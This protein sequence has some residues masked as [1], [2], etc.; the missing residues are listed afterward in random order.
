MLAPRL[1]PF[2][3]ITPPPSPL[4]P[5]PVHLCTLR[6]LSGIVSLSWQGAPSMGVRLSA[7]QPRRIY[8]SMI[9]Y[10]DRVMEIILRVC[11]LQ[12][13]WCIYIQH[14]Y[15]K[16]EDQILFTQKLLD[17]ILGAMTDL[18]TTLHCLQEVCTEAHALHMQRGE[19]GTL[20]IVASFSVCEIFWE[21]LPILYYPIEDDQCQSKFARPQGYV[22]TCN[23]LQQLP[24]QCNGI[25]LQHQLHVTDACNRVPTPITN[26]VA[27]RSDSIGCWFRPLAQCFVVIGL[28]QLDL[29][30]AENTD[31]SPHAHMN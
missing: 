14:K 16:I 20:M 27:W 17:R 4:V 3:L 10:I 24:I 8:E 19:M 18:R 13:A 2:S 29:P 11:D 25:A 28:E 6:T 12:A 21:N 31:L 30:L 7:L 26:D 5:L 22:Y 1:H 15:L 23:R 9:I